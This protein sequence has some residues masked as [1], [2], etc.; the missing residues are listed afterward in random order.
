VVRK[1]KLALETLMMFDPV[2]AVILAPL[3]VELCAPLTL[4]GD[5]NVNRNLIPEA[6]LAALDQ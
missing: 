1:L 5:G 2:F 3:Q 4:S 6:L